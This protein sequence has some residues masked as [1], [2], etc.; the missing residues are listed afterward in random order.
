MPLLKFDL[1]RVFQSRVGESEENMRKAL[2]VAEGVAPAILWIDE[3]EKGLA[4]MGA[5]TW[6]AAFL[7]ASSATSSLG[8][9]KNKNPCLS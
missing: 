7:P 1:G 2:S 9:K 8:W 6:M 3:L 5:P 4:G